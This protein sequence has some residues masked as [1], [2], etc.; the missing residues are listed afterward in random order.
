MTVTAP[1]P[2]TPKVTPTVTAGATGSRVNLKWSDQADLPSGYL[3]LGPGLHE[4]GAEVE[5]SR[6]GQ[7]LN[8]DNVPAGDHTIRLENPGDDWLTIR[9][10]T[11]SPY[12]PV[13]GAVGKASKDYAAYWLYRRDSGKEPVKAKLTVNG[14]QAGGYR[15]TW[16][17]ASTGKQL[18]QDDVSASASG[19]T[20]NS[21][22]VETDMALTI[23]KAGEKTASKP[24]KEDKGK[25]SNAT[26]TTTN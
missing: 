24:P 9:R 3:V 5:A 8:V 17:D 13:L 18:S 10:I 21:P 19:L 1:R 2:I 16:W 4:N 6:T 22:A 14:L 12:A 20:L 15:A 26:K 7:A 23:A 11:L 25:A